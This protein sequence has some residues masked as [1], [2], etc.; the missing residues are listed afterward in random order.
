MAPEQ[1]DGEEADARTDIFAFGAVLF[2]MLTGQKAFTGK[3]QA[4]LLG[5]ILKDEPPPVSQIAPV[6][7]PALD[8]V[9]RTCLARDPDARFQTVHDLQLQLN[10]IAEG[11]SAAGVAASDSNGLYARGHLVFARGG[12]LPRRAIR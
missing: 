6:A 8:H 7:P 5:A 9:V 12:T 10:W 11:G 4:S 1:I 2:E 3:S